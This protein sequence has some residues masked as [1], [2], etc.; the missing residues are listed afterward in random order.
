MQVDALPFGER[1]SRLLADLRR[2]P[3][4]APIGLGKRTSNL[5]RDRKEPSK[6]RLDLGEFCH[7]IEVRAADGWVDA[8]GLT[9]YEDMVAATLPH[10]AMPA[11]VPQLKTITIGGAAAGV[12]IE[13]TSFR[14]GLMH[15]TVTELEV[16]LPSGD[17]VLCT[18]QNEYSDLFFGF[19]NSY[20][21]LGYA[22]RLR[23]RTL[24][25]KSCVRVEHRRFE[26]SRT[27][28]GEVSDQCE[29]TA[30]FID[31]VVFGPHTLVLNIARF[32][33]EA[34]WLSD[35]GFE[36]IYYRS[37]LEKET[38]YLDVADYL[39]RWDT[40]WFWCSKNL[41][42]QHPIVRHLL[43]RKRLNSRTYTRAMR[44]NARWGLTRRLDRL[45]GRHPEAVIQDVDIPLDRAEEFLDFLLR[46]IGIL[47]IWICPL[48]A[49]DAASRYPL[50]PLKAGTLYVNF[51]FWDTIHARVA[52]E[53]GHFNRRIEQETIRLGGIKSLYSDSFF[54]REEFAQAY[55]TTQLAALK[56]KYDPQSRALD[57]YDKCVLRA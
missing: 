43:G 4:S 50:Y 36:H 20:G 33:D 7:V 16:L 22:L 34:P 32:V 6:R 51:G 40:D 23:Q 24:R 41:G 46:E 52:H 12:G 42:A 26:S 53:P 56:A 14:Y 44:W 38:D 9:T 2:A 5:F 35:Y 27:Y 39:W 54:T 13:A 3:R 31:G 10:G 18:P 17:V 49:V 8:E 21:T 45:R 48:R 28:F 47:P 30:D 25:V 11:V 29:G 15:E 19:P 37:L 57:L 1:K 55:G